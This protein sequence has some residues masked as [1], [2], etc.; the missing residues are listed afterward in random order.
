VLCIRSQSLTPGAY[1]A[2]MRA[3][4]EPITQVRQAARHP[5]VAEI[6]ILSS[7]DRDDLGDGK[8]LVVGAH[9]HSDDSYKAVKHRPCPMSSIRW[10]API[11]RRDAK[12]ST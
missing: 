8:R 7:E 10:C 9:W 12:R 11:P 6:M 3:F 5:E 4:G 2:A 1:L